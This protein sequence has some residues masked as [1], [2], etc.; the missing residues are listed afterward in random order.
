M[1]VLIT[2]TAGFIGNALALRM[3]ERGD[4]VAGLDIVDDTYDPR[5]KE[6]R[7]ERIRALP[8][9]REARIALEDGEE[10][11]ALFADFRPQ[12]VVHL[13][14]QVGVRY[15]FENPRA[16]VESNVLG[17][18]NVLEGCR[19]HGVEHL[20]FASSSSVYGAATR[21][22][23]SVRD[24]VDHPI[25]LYAAT[26]K[27]NE[28]MAHTYSHNF[29]LPSTGLRFFTV[30]GPW[31]RPDMAVFRFTK[32]IQERRPIEVYNEGKALRDFTFIEDVVEAVLR[33]SDL[34]AAPDPKWRGEAPEANTSSAP[35]R[36]YN[37][38]NNNPVEL[39]RLI[40]IIEDKLGLPAEKIMLPSQPGDMQATAA[41]VDDLER[42]IGFRPVTGIEEGIGLFV[43]WYKGYYGN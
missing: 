9:F 6:G 17:F 41:E 15:C 30:Y 36:I 20:V 18:M 27:A 29:G 10:V 14:A 28:L 21:L 4:A 37:I 26:K 11:A 2:G 23:Y 32:A 13:A 25:S 35:Y 42:A 22:P 34:P 39:L 31:G 5:L 38:G 24:A 8:Q 7:L 40:E 33:I 1:R 19:R 43:E 12:R 3:L 16:Y